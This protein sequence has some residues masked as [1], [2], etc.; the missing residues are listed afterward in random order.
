MQSAQTVMDCLTLLEW[1]TRYLDHSKRHHSNATYDE[2]RTVFRRLVQ[3]LGP[4]SPVESVTVAVAEAHLAGQYDSRGP[5]AANKDRK[6]LAVAWTWGRKVLDGMPGGNPWLECD[7]YGERRSPRYVPP[8]ADFWKVYGVAEGQDQLML[9]AC[10]DLALR[11]GELFALQWR[12]LDLSRDTAS[13]RTIKMRG[14]MEKV[15][16]LPLTARLKRALLQWWE[17]RP[18]K[19]PHVFMNLDQGSLPGS[20]YG[21]PLQYRQHHMRKLCQKAGVE[22]FGYHAIR[23]L[24]ATMLF[25]EGHA[26][27]VIQGL[28]RHE[29]P[30]TTERYLQRLGLNPHRAAVTAS[31]QN[32]GP[33]AGQVIEIGTKKAPLTGTQEG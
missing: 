22:P 32:R 24:V 6:N 18:V 27:A 29:S 8:E 1:A 13:V 7:R 15:D 10:F 9:L 14:G 26:L 23:H 3:D 19:R 21:A 33:G 2:K 17:Q 31:L 20:V 16:L 11:R 30:Q 4:D 28:L 5:N 25:Q 12:D